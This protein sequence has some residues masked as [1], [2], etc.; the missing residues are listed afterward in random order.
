MTEKRVAAVILAAGRSSRM[1][2][3]KQ[4]LEIDGQTLL[5]RTAEI[6]VASLEHAYVILGFE[7]KEVGE[8][9]QNLAISMVEAA[10]WEQGLSASVKAGVGAVRAKSPRTDAILF[11]PCDL[12]LLSREHLDALVGVYRSCSAPL[13]VSAWDD[14]LGIPAL[15]DSSLWPEFEDLTGDKGARQIIRLHQQE[16]KT[17]PFPAGKFDLDTPQ[18]LKR[19]RCFS[20][21]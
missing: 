14:V 10:E 1:G 13:V 11:V 12:P 3:P 9:L 20:K 17:V 2:T 21:L 5:R 19:F 7:A 8:T 18:Q 16:A 6:A 15:F 4:L